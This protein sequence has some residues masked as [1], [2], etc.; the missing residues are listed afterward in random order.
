MKS[1]LGGPL[2]YAQQ[3]PAVWGCEMEWV[4]LVLVCTLPVEP[5]S[6]EVDIV[7]INHYYS[8]ETGD[9]VFDQFIFWGWD[10]CKC[11]FFVRS[12]KFVE[13]KTTSHTVGTKGVT[14]IWLDRGQVRVIRS[15]II[16]ET[17]TVYDRE[18]EDRAKRPVELRKKI[19]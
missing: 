18:V 10:G 5:E 16:H 12:W 1:S 4:F 9:K 17:W 19:F 14:V 11:E 2:L 8:G 15:K 3:R 6:V 13:A 7:E